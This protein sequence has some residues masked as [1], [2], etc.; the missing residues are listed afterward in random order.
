MTWAMRLVKGAA[1]TEDAARASKRVGKWT[2]I[3]FLKKK[4]RVNK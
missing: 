1:E 3:V 4:L 2:I